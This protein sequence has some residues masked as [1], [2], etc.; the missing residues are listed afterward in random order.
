ME[1]AVFNKLRKQ[2][3]TE[4]GLGDKVSAEATTSESFIQQVKRVMRHLLPSRS[5][6]TQSV[7]EQLLSLRKL[8]REDRQHS[9]N[10]PITKQ[11]CKSARFL[12]F[13]LFGE[14]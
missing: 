14:P 12:A 2:Q 7:Y 11:S 8:V 6:G 4:C 10:K 1:E 3:H 13:I 5:K 9:Q